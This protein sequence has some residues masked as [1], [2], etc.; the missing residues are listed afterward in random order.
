MQKFNLSYFKQGRQVC[1]KDGQRVSNLHY[2]DAPGL[3][4]PL[5][6]VIEG[7]DHVE[8]WQED[9]SFGIPSSIVSSEGHHLDLMICDYPDEL[10]SRSIIAWNAGYWLSHAR[11]LLHLADLEMP[12]NLRRAHHK[13]MF[14]YNY[15]LDNMG[16]RK[17]EKAEVDEA[18]EKAYS[19]LT[20]TDEC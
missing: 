1:T 3:L 14:T 8:S 16:L 12:G 10:T 20:L 7:S 2:F 11:G 5:H 13:N 19:I 15:V 17:I 9:G 18:Y 4:W 6:G